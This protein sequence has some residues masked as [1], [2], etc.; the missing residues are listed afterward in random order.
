MSERVGQAN[1]YGAADQRQLDGGY[2][3]DEK[4]T[5]VMASAATRASV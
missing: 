4:D 2:H 5:H 3:A 1:C